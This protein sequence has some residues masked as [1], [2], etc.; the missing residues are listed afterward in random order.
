[1][2][3]ALRS[4]LQIPTGTVDYAVALVMDSCS[5]YNSLVNLAFLGC[6]IAG[7]F[8]QIYM[9]SI[10][11]LDYI[12]LSEYAKNVVRSIVRPRQ[13]LLS[14]LI[15]YLCVIV[16]FGMFGITQFGLNEYL[17]QAG[18]LSADDQK[19]ADDTQPPIHKIHN[20]PDLE[21]GSLT[22]CMALIFYGGIRTFDVTSMM[23]PAF[24]G[25]YNFST[26]IWY[27]ILFF[28]ALGMLLSNM[29]TGIIVDTFADLRGETQE[30]NNMLTSETFISV[31]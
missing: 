2:I 21:C 31:N 23:D 19:A 7:L 8:K 15:V 13:A 1:M 14:L 30:R 16:I 12:L 22:E 28:I 4:F 3:Y 26:R 17:M 10:C 24:P 29:L 25:S 27:D 20:A 18:S 11:L 6:T 9:F 5:N